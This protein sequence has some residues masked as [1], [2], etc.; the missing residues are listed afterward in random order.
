MR[1]GNRI[2]SREQLEERL[3]HLSNDELIAL[4]SNLYAY[5]PDTQSLINQAAVT[6]DDADDVLS[7]MEDYTPGECKTALAA[8][9]KTI[10][11]RKEKVLY[12]FSFV[13]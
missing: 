10:K 7:H 4:V 12:Y 6:R 2:Y 8:Y 9:V 13:E 3:S 11:N 5:C 1:V